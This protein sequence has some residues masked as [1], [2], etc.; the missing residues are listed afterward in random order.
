MTIVRLSHFKACGYCGRGIREW[1]ARVGLDYSDFLKN[2]IEDA[3]LVAK[4]DA[5]VMK[6]VEVARNGKE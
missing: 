1:F 6:A 3:I 2:G 4:D 5:M